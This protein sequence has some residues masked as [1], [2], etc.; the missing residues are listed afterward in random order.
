MTGMEVTRPYDA[1]LHIGA[2]KTGSSAIQ[3]FLRTNA[4]VLSQYGFAIP[5]QEFRFVPQ[6]SGHQVFGFQKF[7]DADGVGLFHRL[8]FMMQAR[9]GRTVILSAE[10]ISN[11]ENYRYFRKFCQE[12]R[13]KVIFYIRRQD[14]YLA[15]AWQQWFGKVHADLDAWLDGAMRNSAHWGQVIDCWSGMIGA[16]DVVPRVFERKYFEAGDVVQ[17]FAIA[18]GLSEAERTNLIL[19]AREINPSYSHVITSLVA[20]R[21]DLFETAHDNRFYKFI[22]EL[23]A[24]RY[25]GGGDLSLI[26]RAGRARIVAHYEQEN[27]RVR[28]TYFPERATLFAPLDHET[29]RYADEVDLRGEQ[30]KFLLDVVISAFNAQ[31]AT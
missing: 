31:R 1:I 23:T 5:S 3:A 20:G 13:T 22:A 18:L 19:T 10:N 9:E 26:S 30:V 24:G 29:Y 17:D 27:E 14:D 12:F 15:S 7:F 6:I 4:P 25:T 8:N 21:R 28:A 16:G 2:G 11:G